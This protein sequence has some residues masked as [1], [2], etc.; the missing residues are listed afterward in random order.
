MVESVGPLTRHVAPPKE[1]LDQALDDWNNP[2]NPSEVTKEVTSTIFTHRLPLLTR[3]TQARTGGSQQRRITTI[4]MVPDDTL[5][6]IFDFYRSDA[7]NQSR[8]RPWKWHRLA[9]VCKRWRYVVSVSPR[10]LG[11][12]ILCKSKASIKFILDSWPTLPLV[13][14]YKAP[15]SKSLPKNFILALRCPDRV[16]EIELVLPRSLIGPI[17]EVIVGPFQALECVQIEVKNATEPPMLVREAFLGGSA[18]RLRVIKLDGI[19]F[20]FSAIRQVLLSSNDLLQLDLSNIPKDAYVSPDDLVTGLSTLVQLNQLRISF[21]FPSS[22]PPPSTTRPP[23]QRIT[24]PC[25]KI[26]SFCGATEY[27]EE[28]IARIDLPALWEITIGLFNQ[29]FFE[30]PQFCQ[31]IPRLDVL[32]FPTELMVAP[33]AKSVNLIFTQRGKRRL[34]QGVWA[35]GTSCERLD[36]QLSFV[37]QILSQLSPLLPSVKS[38]SIYKPSG[39][40]TREDMDPAQWVELF[41]PFTHVK[42]V[43]IPDY[44]VPDIV[45]VLVAEDMATGVFPEL[46]SLYL[47]GYGKSPSVAK[48]AEQFV[49]TRRQSGQTIDLSDLGRAL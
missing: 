35:L 30:I 15:K 47:E 48:A 42:T 22:V 18:P 33:A 28:F 13:V 19:A 8:G 21:H 34:V 38:F 14:R 41:R 36:W 4:E 31:F 26:L 5:L 49:A 6:E 17:V 9:H 39:L 16:R 24:L 1:L 2:T 29:V 7:I 27:L 23:P 46:N 45:D 44:L 43:H 40:P 37:T 10:R 20:P 12:Q 32:K 11:L 3:G 25:L